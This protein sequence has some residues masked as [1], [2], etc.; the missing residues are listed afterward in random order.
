MILFYWIFLASI[1]FQEILS[2]ANFFGKKNTSPA[3]RSVGT[4]LVQQED[5]AA[6][7][8]GPEQRRD[9]A[10]EPVVPAPL[11]R[12]KAETIRLWVDTSS[13]A[14]GARTTSVLKD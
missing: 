5:G 4:L 8:E 1:Q 2:R 12:G 6:A 3:E 14:I 7:T 10:S 11:H 9:G 13:T